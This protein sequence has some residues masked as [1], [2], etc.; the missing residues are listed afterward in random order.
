VWLDFFDTVL[1]RVRVVAVP[2]RVVGVAVRLLTVALRP[3]VRVEDERVETCPTFGLREVRVVVVRTV[4]GVLVRAPE[5]TVR[6]PPA[7]VL[8]E[9]FDCGYLTNTREFVFYFVGEREII[10]RTEMLIHL[11]KKG[12]VKFKE[13][14]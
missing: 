1:E 2:E 9:E 10:P 3:L 13:G 5:T 8:V 11:L 4:A 6:P 12:I 14:E 7:A